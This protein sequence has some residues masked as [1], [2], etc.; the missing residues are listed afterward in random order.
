MELNKLYDIAD[1]NNIDVDYFPMAECK[2][3]STRFGIAIDVDKLK[4]PT[5]EK[6]CLAHELG[7]CIKGAFYNIYSAFDIRSKHEYT[8]N[9]WAAH[10]LLPYNELENAFKLGY[11]EAWQIAELF[12]LTEDFVRTAINIYK[13]ERGI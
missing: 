4:N 2:S 11:T 13:N 10:K 3:L 5:E 8:A 6:V 1:K 9:K 12:N 7:H